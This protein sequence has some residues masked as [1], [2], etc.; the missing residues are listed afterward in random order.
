MRNQTWFGWFYSDGILLTGQI[1]GV[2]TTQVVNK[3]WKYSNLWTDK[4]WPVWPAEKKLPGWWYSFWY[5]LG[6]G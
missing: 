5:W 6:V 1:M 4:L 2:T 3:G